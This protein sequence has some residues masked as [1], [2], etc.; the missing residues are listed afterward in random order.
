[1]SSL[2]N[3]PITAFVAAIE[4]TG[5]PALRVALSI[6]VLFFLYAGV[7]IFRRRHQYFDRDPNVEN[8]VS[9]VRHIRLRANSICLGRSDAR[10]HHH[11]VP[12]VAC[13]R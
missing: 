11:F 9:A 4:P 7:L 10:S 5:V 8:D 13:M 6:A 3:G 2:I 1:M 12:G